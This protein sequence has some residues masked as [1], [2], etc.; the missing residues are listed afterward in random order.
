MYRVY[1][2]KILFLYLRMILAVC[3]LLLLYRTSSKV[4]LYT[5]R[6]ACNDFL[7]TFRMRMWDK[8]YDHHICTVHNP[9]SGQTRFKI[10]GC[11]VS[12]ILY[13][14]WNITVSDT[15]CHIQSIMH[16]I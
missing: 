10:L 5:V 14:S 2:N 13:S 3:I 1:N 7:V 4:L 8:F 12:F 11:S 9:L 6:D 15:P 16:L